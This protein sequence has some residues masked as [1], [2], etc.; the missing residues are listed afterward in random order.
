M[1]IIHSS[2]VRGFILGAALLAGLG[3]VTHATARE[4]FLIDLNSRTVTY[5]GNKTYVSGINAA[6]QMAGS[7]PTAEGDNHAFITGPDGRSMRDLGTFR[8]KWQRRSRH[9][10]CRAGGGV[11]RDERR[12]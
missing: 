3:H 11:G 8:R 2:N 5:F 10:Q 9:Q 6:G 7:S 4:Y 1:K 12:F